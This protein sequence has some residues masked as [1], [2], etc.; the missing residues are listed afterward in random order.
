MKDRPLPSKPSSMKK[1]SKG[2][3]YDTA[4]WAMVKSPAAHKAGFT[5]VYVHIEA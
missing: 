3:V 4:Q 5:V 2:H 1:K